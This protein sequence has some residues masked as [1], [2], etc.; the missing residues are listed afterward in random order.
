MH[1]GSKYI[2]SLADVSIS[3]V[4]E[5]GGK[6][7][8]LGEMIGHLESAGIA[9]PGGCAVTV[10]GF[11]HFMRE[12]GLESRIA[13]LLDGLANDHSNL[14]DV[15]SAIR[16]AITGAVMPADLE[17]EIKACYEA[18]SSDAGETD[19][20]V[21]V[22]SSATAEDLP[23]ASFA[24]QQATFLYIRGGD[25]VVQAAKDCFASLYTDRAIAYRVEKGYADTRVGLSVGIQRMVR[26]DTGAA[27]VAFSIDTESGF[28]RTVLINGAVGLGEAVVQGFVDPDEFVVFKPLLDRYRPIVR[29][30]LGGKQVKM[31]QAAGGGT[32]VINTDE[33]E[34]QRFCLSDDDIL[35]LA[36][37]VVAIEAHYG[38]P[39][40]VEWAKD[41]VDGRLFVVQAR[42]ETV[43]SNRKAGALKRYR[44]NSHGDKLTEGVA[45]GDGI[46]VGQVRVLA[47]PDESER[48][49]DGEVLVTTSTDPDWLPVMRRAAAIVTERGGRT[50]HAA[51][52]SRE[53]GLPAITG[54]GDATAVLSDGA[55]VTV[56]CCEGATG[57][58]YD[59]R[60]EY[61]A[62]ELDLS[63]LPET[64]TAVMLNLADPDAATEWW[65]VPA[66]GVGLARMEFVVSNH[67][68]A[69]PLALLH[70]EQLPADETRR[71]IEALTAGY[72]S[73]REFFIEQLAQGI[74]AIAAV[75]WPKPVI[76]RTSDFKSNEYADLLGGST[77]EPE[78][79]NPMLGWRGASRYL[80]PD[81]Q[82][83]FA[84]ECEA[85]RRVRDEMGFDNVV[86]MIPFC[87]TPEEAERIIDLLAERGLQRGKRGLEIYAMCEV[88][89][90]VLLVREFARLFDGFSIGSNDLTQLVL[91]ID[92]DNDRLQALFDENHRAVSGAIREV[93]RLAH[94]EGCKV[95]LCGQGPS[96]NPQFARFLVECGID[97]MSVSP[98]SFAT[99]KENVAAAERAA[100][101]PPAA[102]E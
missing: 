77:Y 94:A 76:V 24:G 18:L 68:K 4:E 11:R 29:K 54:S 80:H 56:S 12:N 79:E 92:R 63:N 49:Q 96:D 67:I 71:Q 31:V 34:R 14:A 78:E 43:Q 45:I 26:S 15:G 75:G 72:P 70:L 58:V 5:V 35:A 6:N 32:P 42:P 30:K 44:L 16:D 7:A 19:L 66:D 46:A 97:S 100:E 81:Y 9:V 23:D 8:S 21:A 89:S 28:D 59:G 27:G 50:S 38:R 69:H 60:A 1:N 52:V 22:R 82:D 101:Q 74:A 86:V 83:A 3:D 90:N 41:G 25:A 39:M 102:A 85:L 84:M 47:S 20:P 91:G 62:E 95:G 36:R 61:E 99:V 87:R 37:C 2:V 73:G 64:Q 40:D 33:R 10:H 57:R 48:F 65:R 93:I 98:D 88:P 53:L 55:A 51:I 17:A 13:A